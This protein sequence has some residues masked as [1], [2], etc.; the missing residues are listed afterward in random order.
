MGAYV[1][2]FRL[3]LIL[4]PAFVRDLSVWPSRLLPI[5]MGKMNCTVALSADSEACCG[6]AIAWTERAKMLAGLSSP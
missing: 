1:T 3:G 4:T 5:P 6:H 2:T